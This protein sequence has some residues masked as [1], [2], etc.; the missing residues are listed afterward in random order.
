[1]WCSSEQLDSKASDQKELLKNDEN[2]LL[3]FAFHNKPT[4][5]V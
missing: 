5:M 2:F 1:M 3:T 4:L